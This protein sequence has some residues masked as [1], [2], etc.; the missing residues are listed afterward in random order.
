MSGELAERDGGWAEDT[1]QKKKMG[2]R[3]EGGILETRIL[4]PYFSEWV[5]VSIWPWHGHI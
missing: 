5:G 1:E 4:F 2:W 3:E